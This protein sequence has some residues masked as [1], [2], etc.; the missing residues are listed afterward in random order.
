M[1]GGGLG[2]EALSKLLAHYFLKNF[3]CCEGPVLS[4]DPLLLLEKLEE[5]KETWF[6]SSDFFDMRGV[7]FH[8]KSDHIQ[9]FLREVELKEL[10]KELPI[11]EDEI[12][13]LE[14]THKSLEQQRKDMQLKRSELDQLQRKEEMKLG[15]SFRKNR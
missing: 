1:K 3:S 6:S 4:D 8:S 11:L 15:W 10:E 2:E 13:Q 14:V 12:N 9:P 5:G 7:Y